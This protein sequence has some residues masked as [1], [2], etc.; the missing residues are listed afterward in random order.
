M[1]NKFVLPE[2]W[3]VKDCQ[4][5]TEY[6]QTL[7]KQYGNEITDIGVLCVNL[8]SNNSEWEHINEL[9][10]GKIKGYTL[11]TFEQFKEYVL[12][13]KSEPN[14]YTK[15]INMLKYINERNRTLT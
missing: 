1:K 3:C 13:K 7:K 2:K 6:S 12:N 8:N 11:I 9:K 10:D 4:E 5:V 15:L 14:N